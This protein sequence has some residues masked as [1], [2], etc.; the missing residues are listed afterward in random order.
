MECIAWWCS[1]VS[2]LTFKERLTSVD[3]TKYSVLF[4]LCL[5]PRARING[6]FE[7][8]CVL[9]ISESPVIALDALA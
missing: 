8:L 3:T 7:A 1:T 6:Y 5:F 2:T 4:Q 9:K